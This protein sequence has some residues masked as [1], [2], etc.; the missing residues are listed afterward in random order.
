M[1]LGNHRKLC[2]FYKIFKENKPT[3]LFNLIPT[4]NSNYDTRNTGKVAIFHTKHNFFKKKFFPSTV[5]EWNNLDPNVWS[6]A[7]LSVFKKN[8]LKVVR[9]SWNS[10][11]NY[12]NS[13]GIKCFTRLRLGLSHLHEHKLNHSFQ[14]IL[15]VWSWCWSKYAFFFFPVPCLVIRDAPS[16]AQLMILIVLS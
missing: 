8:F 9:P 5:T 15:L 11:F 4:K 13:K 6:A 14:D 12:R 1:T 7:S 10:A 16:W 2:S 3:Y